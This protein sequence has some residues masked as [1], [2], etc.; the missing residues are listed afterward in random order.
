MIFLDVNE[1]YF[2][3]KLSQ[4]CPLPKGE[5]SAIWRICLN[6]ILFWLNWIFY[7][8]FYPTFFLF[9]GNQYRRRFGIDL[10]IFTGAEALLN[11]LIA[12]MQRIF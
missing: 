11:E 6:L 7:L 10:T 4:N 8:S 9:L 5:K 2:Q 12:D 1:R 3:K